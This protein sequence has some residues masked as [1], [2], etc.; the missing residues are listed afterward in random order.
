MF[1]VYPSL[2]CEDYAGRRTG[3]LSSHTFN[4]INPWIL[5]KA[6]EYNLSPPAPTQIETLKCYHQNNPMQTSSENV[7]N[8]Q[9]NTWLQHTLVWEFQ[10]SVGIHLCSFE[11][12]SKYH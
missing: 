1:L 10:I 3:A 4:Y 2:S 6:P 5:P 12:L 8:M 7:G 11:N 9:Q